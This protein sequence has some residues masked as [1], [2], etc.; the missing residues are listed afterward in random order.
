MSWGIREGMR[1]HRRKTPITTKPCANGA[2][3][4]WVCGWK[5]AKVPWMYR[6]G[7]KPILDL[8]LSRPEEETILICMHGRAMRMLLCLL[9][10]YPLHCMDIFEH[11][12]LCLYQLTYTGSMFVVNRLIVTSHLVVLIIHTKRFFCFSCEFFLFTIY[13][14]I[15][16]VC[17]IRRKQNFSAKY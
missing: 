3:A 11:Q 14:R 6:P 9:L 10:N 17:N 2:R 5:A 1:L 7:Q 12:N 13:I 8:I 16:F 15:S 4:M